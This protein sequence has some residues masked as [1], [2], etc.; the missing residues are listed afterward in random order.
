MTSAASGHPSV[1]VEP[2]PVDGDAEPA[3]TEAR[4]I[5]QGKLAAH[6]HHATFQ[7][8]IHW[9]ALCAL[10]GAAFVGAVVFWHLVTPP[11][12]H[13]LGG[14]QLREL[15]TVALTI[16]GSSVATVYFEKRTV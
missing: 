4:L 2:E 16:F 7:R 9:I 6:R 12:F 14:D 5:E 15:R 3:L 1:P 8:H 10:W 13:F 11:A